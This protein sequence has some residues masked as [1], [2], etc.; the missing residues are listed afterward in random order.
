MTKIKVNNSR[1]QNE[2]DEQEQWLQSTDDLQEVQ[3]L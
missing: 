1:M 2:K 3:V